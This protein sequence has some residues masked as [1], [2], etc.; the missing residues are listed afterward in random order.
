MKEKVDIHVECIP[1]G[2]LE[3]NPLDI[4]IENKKSKVTLMSYFKMTWYFTG[5][6]GIY[7][8]E[9]IPMK[10]KERYAVVYIPLIVV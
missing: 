7:P 6:D 5:R 9:C 8:V 4:P 10:G 1:I 2:E 3:Y